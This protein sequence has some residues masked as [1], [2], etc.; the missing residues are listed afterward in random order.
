MLS[1]TEMTEFL[2]LV[3]EWFGWLV[4]GYLLAVLVK[5]LIRP[6]RDFREE[7]RGRGIPPN[8]DDK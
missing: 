8:I 4:V 3:C 6:W 2:F 1:P 5:N 7:G